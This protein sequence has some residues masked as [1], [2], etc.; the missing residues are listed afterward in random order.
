MISIIDT[1]SQRVTAGVSADSPNE[2]P[3][4]H[5]YTPH[6]P[7]YIDYDD[8]FTDYGFPGT[9]EP[10]DP[11]RIENYNITVSGDYP[12]LFS[13]NNTKHFVIQNCFIK[14]DTNYGIYLGKYY[15]MGEGTVNILDNIIIMTV[16]DVG[17]FL[18]GGNYSII[19][20]NSVTSSDYCIWL[21]NSFG[22][23]V[24]ENVILELGDD[25][26]VLENSDNS[27]ISGN[28]CVGGYFGI[29]TDKSSNLLINHN[30]C[31]HNIIGIY[32]SDGTN[33]MVTNNIVVNNDYLGI[34]TFYCEDTVF[35]NN[36]FQDNG[37]YGI[38]VGYNS[39]TNIIHHNAFINNNLA[40]MSQAKDDGANNIWYD[41]TI[42]EGNYWY[43]GTI[44]SSSYFIDG[45]A[46]SVDPYPLGSIPEISEYTS[47]Y[48]ILTIFLGFLAIPL[49]YSIN[50]KRNN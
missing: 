48:L 30:N 2:Y 13:G 36:L 4:L 9:G 1:S 12:I 38:L 42:N 39:D 19:S 7:I 11:Y 3:T 45:T 37:E 10:E 33:N 34:E 29:H 43:N 50:R 27:T 6:G 46:G 15:D 14:S 18:D 5:A 8:N 23:F 41:D 31:T 32:I 21:Q 20:G 47:T 17:I 35:R 24:S 26:L 22:S 44:A 28:T 40:G 25:G 16:Y 49:I